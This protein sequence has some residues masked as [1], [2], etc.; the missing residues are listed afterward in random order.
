MKKVFTMYQTDQPN[1][2]GG[3][4]TYG[5]LSDAMAALNPQRGISTVTAVTCVES[6]WWHGRR[7]GCAYEVLSSGVIYKA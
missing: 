4:M 3:L 1:V 5:N 6:G 2:L 7:T